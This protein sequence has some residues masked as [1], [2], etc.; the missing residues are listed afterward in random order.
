MIAALTAPKQTATALAHLVGEVLGRIRAAMDGMLADGDL[1]EPVQM[2]PLLWEVKWKL[3]KQGEFRLYHA[4]P[5][6]NPDFVALR[7]HQ[8]DVSSR[9]DK[10]IRA[11]QNVEIAAA[12]Q[13]HQDGLPASW[14]HRRGCANCLLY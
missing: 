8:K 11:L 14:G 3:K 9:D 10:T 6:T 7:F 2:D 5:L 4:E 13:R 1:L 12:G